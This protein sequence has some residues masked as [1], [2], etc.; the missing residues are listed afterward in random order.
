V[1]EEILI[2]IEFTTHMLYL[3]VAFSCGLLLGY[4]VGKRE[5]DM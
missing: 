2:F 1:T 3:F 5:G 4:L